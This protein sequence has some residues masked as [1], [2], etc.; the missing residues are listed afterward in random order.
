MN[1]DERGWTRTRPLT[2][3]HMTKLKIDFYSDILSVSAVYADDKLERLKNHF[4]DRL[5]IVYHWV[6]LYSDTDKP[7]NQDK[8]DDYYHHL[9]NVAD[10]SSYF[11]FNDSI[12]KDRIR[13]SSSGAHLFLKAIEILSKEKLKDPYPSVHEVANRYR[14]LYFEDAEDL[15][16]FLVLEK[17]LDDFSIDK[18]EINEVI[19]SS[20]A[21]IGLIEDEKLYNDQHAEPILPL[22]SMEEGTYKLYGDPTYDVIKNMIENILNISTINKKAS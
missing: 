15:S 20:E 3:S 19:R 2:E 14:R 18:G 16:N 5:E 13:T 1:S 17:V 4:G 22:I 6:S 7:R 8:V 12:W 11:Q 21:M 10:M 9:K